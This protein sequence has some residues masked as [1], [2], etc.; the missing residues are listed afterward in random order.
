[1]FR[2]MLNRLFKP[3][4]RV[5]FAVDIVAFPLVIY[6]LKSLS[7]EH[8]VALAAYLISAYALVITVVNFKKAYRRL[9]ELLTGDELA[10]VRGVKRF[11]RRYSLTRRYLESKD[12]RAEAGL[13]MGLV[14]NLFY[15][16]FKAITGVIYSSAWLW[17]M[18]IYYLFLGGIRFFLMRGERTK[19][20]LKSSN[21]IKLHEFRTYRLCG[22]LMILDIAAGGMAVQ[23]IWQNKA[24]EF[25]R[26]AVII[27]AAYTFY[28]FVLAI[29]NVVSFRR[30]SNAILSAAKDLALTGAVMSMFSLQTSMLHVFGTDNERHFRRVMNTVTG[31]IV[32]AIVLAIATYMIINGTRKTDLYKKQTGG[33]DNE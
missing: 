11:L 33:L 1:M 24:N 4:L 10:P 14:I 13:Y 8:P 6:S 27:S 21:D 22:C 3:P 12:F 20:S 17:S 31:S 23:M 28:M 26:A 16:A 2:K 7:S 32:M 9:K 29:Y 30:R 18:G 5:L 25:S 15:A 19:S